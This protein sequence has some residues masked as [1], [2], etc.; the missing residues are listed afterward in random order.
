MIHSDLRLGVTICPTNLA[1]SLS[2]QGSDWWQSIFERGRVQSTSRFTLA[3]TR[4][5]LL[6]N[7][8]LLIRGLAG[9]VFQHLSCVLL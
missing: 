9:E 7:D 3:E 8:W 4:E 2:C 5:F 6:H 1:G